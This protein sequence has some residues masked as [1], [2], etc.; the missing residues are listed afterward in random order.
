MDCVLKTEEPRQAWYDAAFGDLYPVLYS[1]RDDD[2]AARE[3]AHLVRLLGLRR[4]DA[5][6]ILDVCCGT[7]RHV[8]PLRRLGFRVRGIDRS[9]ALL[10]YALM[11]RGIRSGLLRAD[12]RALPFGPAFD[13]VLNLF[14]SFGYFGAE[15][16]NEQA[17]REMA[18][19]LRPGG[20]LVLDH[21]N[22]RVV[23]QTLV[24]RDRRLVGGLDVRQRRWIDGDRVCKA[25]EV[26][27]PDGR[28][29][30]LLESVRLYA[31]DELHGLL[32]ASGLDPLRCYGAL[33]GRRY[34]P[35]SARMIIVAQKP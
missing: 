14:T 21:L 27:R 31:P 3:A 29:H 23:E 9:P 30:E 7:A 17:L 24:P 5:P 35:D 26:R 16:E 8:A 32:A 25:I 22:R 28:R 20:R 11:R 13:L 2:S 12:M 10:G 33:D 6:G 4:E 19:V 18:R 34:A 15:A 1:H